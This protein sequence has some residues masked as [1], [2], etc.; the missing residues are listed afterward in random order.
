MDDKNK[1]KELLKIKKTAQ[2]RFDRLR[3]HYRGVVH[4]SASSE[5]K[6]SEYMVA[7]DYLANLDIEI[8]NLKA[9]IAKNKGR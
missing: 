4:E 6:H 3:K 8:S 5:L 7:K 9:K 1:L 2:N